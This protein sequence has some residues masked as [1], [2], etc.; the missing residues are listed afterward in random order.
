M[1][2]AKEIKM[3]WFGK[4]SYLASLQKISLL[5]GV[6]E[7]LTKKIIRLERKVDRLQEAVRK[8]HSDRNK[9]ATRIMKLE[10]TRENILKKANP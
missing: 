6:V 2:F 5:Q 9:L 7:Q 10:D 4:K 8:S 3:I 1:D